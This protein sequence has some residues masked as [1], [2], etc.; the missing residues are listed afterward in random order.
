MAKVCGLPKSY[1]K[2]I[3]GE[4]S[5]HKRLLLEGADTLGVTHLVEDLLRG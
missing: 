3:S 1:V 4:T 5:H 2:I